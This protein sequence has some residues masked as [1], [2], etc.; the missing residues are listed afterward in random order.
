MR[1]SRKE[2]LWIDGLSGNLIGAVPNGASLSPFVKQ[3]SLN[4]LSENGIIGHEK[5]NANV[6]GFS[7]SN[8]AT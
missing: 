3:K 7:P 4:I 1:V 2:C 8:L 5:Y 6:P